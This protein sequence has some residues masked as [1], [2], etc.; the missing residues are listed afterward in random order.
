MSAR[1]LARDESFAMALR[2]TV[3]MIMDSV[4]LRTTGFTICPGTTLRRTKSWRDFSIESFS[5]DN[6]RGDHLATFLRFYFCFRG[7][8]FRSKVTAEVTLFTL[9]CTKKDLARLQENNRARRRKQIFTVDITPNIQT[10]VCLF[11]FFSEE[12]LAQEL[13][14]TK[15]QLE[16][17]KSRLNQRIMVWNISFISLLW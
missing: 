11:P 16:D 7:N 17:T 4:W 13:K 5:V 8:R 10:Y 15:T 12:K 6:K 3:W 9:R 1:S 14:E 2:R